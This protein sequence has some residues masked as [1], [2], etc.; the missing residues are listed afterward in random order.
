MNFDEILKSMKVEKLEYVPA[1]KIPPG[2]DLWEAIKSHRLDSIAIDV[3][4]AV[5][6]RGGRE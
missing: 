2:F 1:A 4:K 5:I 6:F 3:F